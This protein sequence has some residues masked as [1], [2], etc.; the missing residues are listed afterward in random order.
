MVSPGSA[1]PSESTSVEIVALLVAESSA[2]SGVTGAPANPAGAGAT[3]VAGVATEGGAAFTALEPDEPIE[4]I[5]IGSE[6]RRTAAR[7]T[8]ETRANRKSLG[9]WR[10]DGERN[11][12]MASP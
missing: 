12:F 6:G 11:L 10:D 2:A 1:L 5:E 4:F 8:I 9:M 3:A 7:M